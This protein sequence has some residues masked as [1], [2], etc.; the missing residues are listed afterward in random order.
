[1]IDLFISFVLEKLLM[2]ILI[3]QSYQLPLLLMASLIVVLRAQK[4]ISPE[5][6]KVKPHPVSYPFIPA[7]SEAVIE[8]GLWHSVCW[9]FTT[10]GKRI[11]RK[12]C[13][14]LGSRNVFVYAYETT[15]W[16]MGREIKHSSFSYTSLQELKRDCGGSVR[17]QKGKLLAGN[18]GRGVNWRVLCADD[19]VFKYFLS[20]SL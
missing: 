20:G 10:S 16:S 3:F 1:M 7:Y 12:N 4:L 18:W 2:S 6:G 19:S 17:G 8:P 14:V 13:L 9:S 5:S 15:L 11:I